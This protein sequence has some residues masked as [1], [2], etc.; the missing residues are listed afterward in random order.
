MKKIK[1]PFKIISDILEYMVVI[2]IIYC[3]WGFPYC[4][5]IFGTVTTLLIS[6][7]T[8]YWYKR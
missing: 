2:S 4:F 3:I 1:I 6:S 5:K 7:L 8:A